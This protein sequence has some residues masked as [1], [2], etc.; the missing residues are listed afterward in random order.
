MNSLK[1]TW[2][3]KE[4]QEVRIVSWHYA[5]FLVS[6]WICFIG[7]KD[8]DNEQKFRVGLALTDLIR[9]YSVAIPLTCRE[10]SEILRGVTEGMQK[11][12][13]KKAQ[14]V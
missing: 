12:D 9:K 7:K 1:K 8:F 11:M 2:K 4:S 13:D 14:I 10:P 6:N 5:H 3:K